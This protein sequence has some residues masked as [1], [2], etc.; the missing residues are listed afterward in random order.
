MNGFV[1]YPTSE[2]GRETKS[3]KEI[4]SNKHGPMNKIS[5]KLH[6]H[7]TQGATMVSCNACVVCMF[8][9]G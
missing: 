4:R 2:S 9:C 6:A 1:V 8:A 7:A 5:D 3:S